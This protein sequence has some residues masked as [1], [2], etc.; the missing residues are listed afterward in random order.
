MLTTLNSPLDGAQ[1][2]AVTLDD[3]RIGFVG[4]DVAEALG[5]S[6][7]AD[8]LTKHCK[9]VAFRY[10]LPTPGGTQEVRILLEPD[11][12]RLVVG[13]RLPAAERFEA[14]VFEEVL[15]TLI[16][17]GAYVG[18][19]LFVPPEPTPRPVRAHMPVATGPVAGPFTAP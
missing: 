15:P 1:I 14:W 19:P 16:R 11:V 3:G 8:A 12:Y 2:R 17:T 6:N 10:P 9:G 18:A 4:K 7:P 5:Y 13:S